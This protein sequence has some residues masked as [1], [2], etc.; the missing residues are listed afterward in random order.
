MAV[1]DEARTELSLGQP[2]V[3]MAQGRIAVDG[4]K[5]KLLVHG[6]WVVAGV[7]PFFLSSED[8]HF[9]KRNNVLI[10]IP[11]STGEL[12]AYSIID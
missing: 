1:F 4:N 5:C 11:I 12:L 6:K 10:A 9:D 8:W 2:G 3:E 7:L